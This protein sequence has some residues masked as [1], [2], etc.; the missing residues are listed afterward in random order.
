MSTEN[1][2]DTIEP[3]L[4]LPNSEIINDILRRDNDPP[5]TPK[6][7]YR[8]WLGTLSDEKLREYYELVK[9]ENPDVQS[10]EIS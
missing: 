7:S 4:D 5:L 1:E 10:P 8:G 9:I 3:P 2:P 6:R